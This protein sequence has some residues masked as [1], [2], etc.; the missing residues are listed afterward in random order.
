[1]PLGAKISK[2]N[3]KSN[4]NLKGTFILTIFENLNVGK[5]RELQVVH[6]E[7]QGLETFQETVN[8]KSMNYETVN[9]EDPRTFGILLIL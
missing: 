8:C 7:L 5:N 3:Q 9:Y 4:T 1:M 6:R 2:E